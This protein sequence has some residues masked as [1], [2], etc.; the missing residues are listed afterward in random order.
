MTIFSLVKPEKL[1]SFFEIVATA[2]KSERPVNEES[3]VSR[4]TDNE[5]PQSEQDKETATESSR[6]WD[7]TTM[8]L[9]CIKFPSMRKRCQASGL[10]RPV[11][12]LFI[13]VTLMEDEDP[14]RR[15]FHCVFTNSRGKDGALGSITPEF[16]ELLFSVPEQDQKSGRES[17]RARMTNVSDQKEEDKAKLEAQRDTEDNDDGDDEDEDDEEDDGDNSDS[18]QAR[19]STQS[20]VKSGDSD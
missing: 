20:T 9:P 7:Y 18:D 1:A 13:T 10:S 2:L 14:H 16:L 8:T 11:D 19:S 4:S 3:I 5:K 6:S 12:P 17:K 15:C